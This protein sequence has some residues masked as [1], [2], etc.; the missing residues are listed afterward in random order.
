M[1][2]DPVVVEVTVQTSGAGDVFVQI[3]GGGQA[4]ASGST[5]SDGTAVLQLTIPD[6]RL[7]SMDAPNLYTCRAIFGNDSAETT[8]GV[9]T[10]EWGVHG[11]LLNGERVIL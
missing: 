6:G 2:I 7:W 9:R 11:L 4:V 8:F 3:C 5:Q 10:L 1:S